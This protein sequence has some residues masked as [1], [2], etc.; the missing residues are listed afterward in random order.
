MK[1]KVCSEIKYTNHSTDLWDFPGDRS[2]HLSGSAILSGPYREK[3]TRR[4][5]EV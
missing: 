1:E 3:Y 5:R 4:Q 2:T